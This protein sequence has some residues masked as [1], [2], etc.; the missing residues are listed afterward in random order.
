MDLFKSL[1]NKFHKKPYILKKSVQCIY[2]SLLLIGSILLIIGVACK[3]QNS[4]SN[5]TSF[6]LLITFIILTIIAFIFVLIEGL[7]FF[8]HKC[9]FKKEM[10]DIEIL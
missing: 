8:L 2:T 5:E 3:K 6:S 1:K 9:C 4:C 7:L 10:N